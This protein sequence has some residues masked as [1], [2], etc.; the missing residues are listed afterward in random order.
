MAAIAAKTQIIFGICMTRF[1]PSP[2]RIHCAESHRTRIS[3]YLIDRNRSG[4][5]RVFAHAMVF[6]LSAI[7]TFDRERRVT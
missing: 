3:T 5:F 7:F 2:R 4:K 1:V 6:G